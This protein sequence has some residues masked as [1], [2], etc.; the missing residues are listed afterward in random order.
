MGCKSSYQTRIPS[1]LIIIGCRTF[2]SSSLKPKL[3]PWFVTGII[4]A[5]GTFCTTI[6]KNKAYKTGWVVISFFEI[7]LNK[8]DSS[9]IYQ[10]KDFFEG[11]GTISLDKKANVLKYST[12]NLKDLSSIVIPHF[13]KYPLLT[14]KD[15]DFLFF[16]QIVELLKKGAHLTINGL[17][18]VINIRASMNTGL[19]VIIKSE[20]S[21]YIN[22]VK[23]GIIHTNIIPDPQWLSGFV[24]GEGGI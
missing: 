8:R 3:N 10:L 19:S 20:F 14:Q 24:S 16:E 4:D 13:K 22:P 18:K 15:A 6:Y 9:L 7:G 23:R 21:N 5:E 1:K 12:A 17:L 11:I 2:S